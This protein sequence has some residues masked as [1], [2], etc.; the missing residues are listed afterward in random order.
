MAFCMKCGR[1][2]P[3]LTIECPHCGHDF[4]RPPQTD[5]PSGWEYSGLADVVLI[6]GAVAS[7]M[8]AV[9]LS[10]LLLAAIV[11][12]FLH[13]VP[14]PSHLQMMGLLCLGACLSLAHCIVFVRVSNLR[15]SRSVDEEP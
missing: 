3:D 8:S 9:I 1:E 6:V 15:Q 11:P 10:L 14:W 13:P 2:V 12:V 7:G 5:T 4:L